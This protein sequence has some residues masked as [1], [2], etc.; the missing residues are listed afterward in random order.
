VHRSEN[1]EPQPEIDELISNI[2]YP[3]AP[4]DESGPLPPATRVAYTTWIL[5]LLTII[6]AYCNPFIVFPEPSKG[7]LMSIQSFGSYISSTTSLLFVV[8]QLIWVYG[9]IIYKVVVVWKYNFWR[10]LGTIFKFNNSKLLKFAD[11]V[12]KIFPHLAPCNALQDDVCCSATT[13]K[14]VAR[15]HGG[16][17]EGLAESISI[18]ALDHL[19]KETFTNRVFQIGAGSMHVTKLTEDQ[20]HFRSEVRGEV[21][22]DIVTITSW[23][24]IAIVLSI[25]Q[26]WEISPK[27]GVI[28][29]LIHWEEGIYCVGTRI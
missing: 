7:I 4:L 13:S 6:W 11:L 23:E 26:L 27:V 22:E 1:D 17:M 15:T 2:D 9:P 5:A 19:S 20:F 24:K 3:R 28:E 10:F 8:T 12:R 16:G 14:F 29:N 18:V 21:L 25:L